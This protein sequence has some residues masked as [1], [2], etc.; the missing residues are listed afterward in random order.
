MPLNVA[1]TIIVALLDQNAVVAQQ[2]IQL[3]VGAGTTFTRVNFALTPPH[4]SSCGAA[5][6]AACVAT[7]ESTCV[8]C[9]G[10]L[11]IR[12][13]SLSGARTNVL[14]DQAFLSPGAWGLYR[15]GGR[16]LPS[17]LDVSAALVGPSTTSSSVVP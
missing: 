6:T 9:T 3:P 2:T 8:T 13:T 5:P 12:V 11:G 15:H 14:L 1:V 4:N 17:R 16:T 7:P 10:A